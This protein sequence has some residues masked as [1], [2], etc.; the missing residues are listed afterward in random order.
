MMGSNWLGCYDLVAR[1][2]ETNVSI[3]FY[4]TVVGMHMG[5][6]SD[7]SMPVVGEE[8][9]CQELPGKSFRSY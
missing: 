4:S 6:F 7:L 5:V 3:G 8:R 2:D 9:V 1:C